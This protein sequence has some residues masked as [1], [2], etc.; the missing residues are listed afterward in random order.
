[1]RSFDFQENRS[2]EL[3]YMTAS[4]ISAGHAFT[5]RY[6]GV[7]EG[8]FASLN[9]GFGRGDPDE[10]VSENYRILGRALGIDVEHAAYT[11]QVHGAEVRVVTAADACAPEAPSSVDCDALVTAERGLPLFCFTADCLPVLLYDGIN[12][13]AAAVHCGWRSSVQDILGRT[14][15]AMCRLGSGPDSICAALGPSIGAGAFETDG[16]VPDALR[17]WLGRAAEEY[18]YTGVV[19]GKYN[20]DLRGAAICRLMQLGVER[21]NIAV[22]REC[23]VTSHDKYWSHRYTAKNGLKRGSQCAFIVLG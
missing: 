17:S 14:V 20:V 3:V 19:E 15:D 7:S 1:M 12:G 4:T 21:G 23:T 22:S 8:D 13:V 18:I 6:G 11:R 16:D 10:N 5:T 9:L 2:G